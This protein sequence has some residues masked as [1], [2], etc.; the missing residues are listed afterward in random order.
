M[1]PD[2]LVTSPPAI[3]FIEEPNAVASTFPNAG[4]FPKGDEATE[5]PTAGRPTSSYPFCRAPDH[6][7]EEPVAIY[8]TTGISCAVPSGTEEPH[9]TQI[10]TPNPY[11]GIC[12]VKS[13]AAEEPSAMRPTLSPP[14]GVC[15][16]ASPETEE[17]A[18]ARV[19][20]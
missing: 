6:T 4:C 17:S 14:L 3:A 12:M 8:V 5:E 7:G 13:H 18:A 1:S 9:A 19:A 16:L 2:S 10:T 15:A 11:R 20:A